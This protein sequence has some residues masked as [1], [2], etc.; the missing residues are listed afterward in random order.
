MCTVKGTGMGIQGADNNKNDP[1]WQQAYAEAKKLDADDGNPNNWI[2]KNVWEKYANANRIKAGTKGISV[3]QATALIYEKKQMDSL[4]ASVDLSGQFMNV[5]AFEIKGNDE[6]AGE[7]LQAKEVIYDTP[8]PVQDESV[9]HN[10]VNFA[11]IF[12]KSKTAD[13]KSIQNGDTD[14]NG[15]LSYDEIKAEVA[16]SND[17]K[18]LK[19][20]A[21][22]LG[23]NTRT[24]DGKADYPVNLIKQFINKSIDLLKEADKNEDMA[25]SDQELES[26]NKVN[27]NSYSSYTEAGRTVNKKARLY[28]ILG[29]TD[30]KYNNEQGGI[31]DCWLLGV[32]Q[33]LTDNPEIY[34][35][36]FKRDDQGVT[37][38]FHGIQGKNGKPYTYRVTNEDIQKQHRLNMLAK[39]NDSTT[40]GSN[41]PDAIALEIAM[42]HAIDK[43]NRNMDN[44][45]KYIKNST[46][47]DTVKPDINK[48]TKTMSRED[49]ELLDNYIRNVDAYNEAIGQETDLPNIPSYLLTKNPDAKTITM[50]DAQVE[51]V[52][53]YVKKHPQPDMSKVYE[54]DY[55]TRLTNGSDIVDYIEASTPNAGTTK[56][57]VL[58]LFGKID[59]SSIKNGGRPETALYM[60]TGVTSNRSTFVSADKSSPLLTQAEFDKYKGSKRVS[61]NFFENHSERGIF[62][63]HEYYI[64]NIEGNKITLADSHDSGYTRTITLKEILKWGAGLTPTDLSKADIQ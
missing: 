20:I 31:G 61:V 11:K 24:T 23:V 33:S 45:L 28:E 51:S 7:V 49:F 50:T 58:G 16:K 40:Y 64:K 63:N 4:K 37:I 41:D 42:E 43:Q 26:F 29:M 32:G 62:G 36:L 1:L 46:T 30:S 53:D 34:N 27:S 9:K 8:K 55:D 25:V 12:G 6:A 17:I 52:I 60:L 13:G 44:I 57:Q 5:D 59:P 18:T 19:E 2:G 48:I 3:A 56:P 10:A 14:G 21:A 47:P 38:S 35:K 22:Y 39:N 54:F 15:K